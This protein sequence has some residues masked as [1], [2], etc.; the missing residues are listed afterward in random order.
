MEFRKEN[1]RFVI[2][3]DC[4]EKIIASLSKFLERTQIKGGF[5]FGIGAISGVEFKS[6]SLKTKK[7]RSMK[8]KGE[9]EIVSLSGIISELGAHVHICVADEKGKCFGGHLNEATVSVTAEIILTE[10]KKIRRKYD[11]KTGLNLLEL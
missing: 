5:F 6:F 7:Y 1:E 2:K 3:F 10:M 8:K 4:G 11:K 9:L